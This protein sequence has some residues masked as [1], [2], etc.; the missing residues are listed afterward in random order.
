MDPPETTNNFTKEEVGQYYSTW[1][2]IFKQY[3]I[4]FI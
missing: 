4:I 3:L 1:D 2:E